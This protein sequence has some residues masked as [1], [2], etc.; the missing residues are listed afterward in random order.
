MNIVIFLNAEHQRKYVDVLNNAMAGSPGV[1]VQAV[2]I[3]TDDR[4]ESATKTSLWERLIELKPF[5]L[6]AMPF[7]AV[8]YIPYAVLMKLLELY[9]IHLHRHW[10]WMVHSA[11]RPV[12][13]YDLHLKLRGIGSRLRRRLSYIKARISPG[14]AVL[15]ILTRTPR[16]Y[17]WRFWWPPTRAFLS[18]RRRDAL[19]YLR[20]RSSVFA[21]LSEFRWKLYLNDQLFSLR[22]DLI[23]LLEDNAEGLTGLVSHIA[24]KRRIPYVILP[25]YIPNPAEP[26]RYYFNNPLHSAATLSGR[27]VRFFAPRWVLEYHGKHL[28]RLPRYAFFARWI[29]GQ[30]C[31]QPWILNAGYTDA[32]FLESKASLKHY[33]YLGFKPEKLRVIGGAV[34]DELYAIHLEKEQ[35][36]KTLDERYGLDPA[37]PLIVCG[38]PPN[39]YSAVAEG[40][41]FKTYDELCQAWFSVLAAAT[42]RANVIVVRH[43]RT[44][45]DVLSKYATG[46]VKI[47]A[48]S[49]ETILPV[50]DV[51]IACISTTIRWALAL[52]IPVI[53]YDTYKYDYG[54]FSSAK[55]CFEVSNIDDFRNKV[56]EVLRSGELDRLSA[57]ASADADEWGL[58]DGNFKNRLR[59]SL[60]EIR[61]KYQGFPKSTHPE[62]YQLPRIN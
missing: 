23:V 15:K 2:E 12:R 33:E 45:A 40:F 26:A 25:N 44:K 56:E 36:R 5:R 28:L 39:Q 10:R 43:P 13:H 47:A 58:M 20:R 34:E 18:R 22:P 53:N 41:E 19:N 14:V 54:D 8:F 50:A 59:D 38:F 61:T 35:Q 16:F 11:L 21:V 3:S 1:K 46:S 29:R 52:A 55:A 32:I 7:G 37:K 57:I 60:L 17:L 24:K 51:Y 30:H 62:G 6:I 42:D 4:S 48:E 27:L 31:P 9:R 49:L